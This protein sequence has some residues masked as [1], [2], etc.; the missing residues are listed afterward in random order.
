MLRRLREGAWAKA[1]V[2]FVSDGEWPDPPSRQT[3]A[4]RKAREAGTRFHGIQIGN[5]GRTGL[6]ALCEPVHVFTDWGDVIGA[7]RD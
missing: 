7:R 1:D 2:L 5:R 6:H 3:A 4:V